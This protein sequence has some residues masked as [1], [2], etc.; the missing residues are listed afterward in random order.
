MEWNSTLSELATQWISEQV[1]YENRKKIGPAIETVLRMATSGVQ[2]DQNNLWLFILEVAAQ[3][4]NTDALERLGA[5]PLED[6]INES[7]AEFFDRIEE[8]YRRSPSFRK[9]L[10]SVWLGA[11]RN[12]LVQVYSPLGCQVVGER[13]DD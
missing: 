1:A 6:L 8:Q 9:A 11:D 12:D 7:G 2:S 3:T 5:G 13:N 4:D 10:S